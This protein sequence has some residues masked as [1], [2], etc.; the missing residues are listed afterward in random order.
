MTRQELDAH[1]HPSEAGLFRLSLIVVVPVCLLAIVFVFASFGLALFVVAS[2]VLSV[3]IATKIACAQY[4]GN[5][6]KVSDQNFGDIQ[7]AIREFQDLFDYHGEVEAY[8]FQDG[9]YNAL[10]VTL[11]RRKFILI[12]SDV[13]ANAESDNEV[14]WI[15][16]RFVG[17][18]ASKHHRFSWLQVV[19]GSIEKIAVFNML[20]YPYERA[21]AK[22]G[23]QLGLL[24]INGD[25]E[26]ALR[27]M[28]KTMAGGA[29]GGRVQLSGL[30]SQDEALQGS[31]FAWLA[32]CL[33]P[34]P[35]T[36]ARLVNLLRYAGERYPLQVQALIAR[37]DDATRQR[38]RQASGLAG[39]TVAAGPLG[40]TA[41]AG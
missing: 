10:L 27:A 16:A 28:Q 34:F 6:V 12:N 20:L 15:V 18:L 39:G 38:I 14:R 19:I 29:L 9:S 3:W 2:I 23:D 35:H 41:Q 32:K 5:C 24:A 11:L 40:A 31:F 36:T 8:I 13:V 1:R 22:S 7:A 26:S 21:I 17:A 30:L 4:L 25:L 37:A 33:S